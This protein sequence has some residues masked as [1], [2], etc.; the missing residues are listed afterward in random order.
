MCLKKVITD[1]YRRN[2]NRLSSSNHQ[3]KIIKMMVKQE[4]LLKSFKSEIFFNHVS[5][6]RSKTHF[7][8]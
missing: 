4:D 6:S 7:K 5:L 2:A 3:K 8:N 1:D